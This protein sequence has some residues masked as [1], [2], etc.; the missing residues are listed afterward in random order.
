[1][2][3]VV[4]LA[5]KPL[6]EDAQGWLVSACVI[7]F[8]GIITVT[9]AFL[10]LSSLG[11]NIGNMNLWMTAFFSELSFITGLLMGG[12]LRENPHTH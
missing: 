8:V 2:R 6:I 12:N 9:I 4:E 3:S 7:I 1:M 10:V 5:M 11:Y